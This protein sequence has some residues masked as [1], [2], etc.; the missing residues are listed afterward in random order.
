MESTASINYLDIVQ[1][2]YEQ[3]YDEVKVLGCRIILEQLQANYRIKTLFRSVRY[4]DKEP[5]VM[6][7]NADKIA[8]ILNFENDY[9]V[10]TGHAI[11][12]DIKDEENRRRSLISYYNFGLNNNQSDL[13]T[14]YLTVNDVDMGSRNSGLNFELTTPASITSWQK[15]DYFSITGCF[16]FQGKIYYSTLK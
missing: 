7:S 12:L 9:R 5:L 1:N 6:Q 15:T 2:Y 16:I 3:F 10:D 13:I 11:E 4:L 14:P 8:N